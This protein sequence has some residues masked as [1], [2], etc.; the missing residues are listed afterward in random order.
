MTDLH[1]S[2][3][4]RLPASGAGCR[5]TAQLS[6]TTALC[7]HGPRSPAFVAGGVVELRSVLLMSLSAEDAETLFQAVSP[8]DRS[9]SVQ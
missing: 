9:Y 6:C 3:S 1:S 2:H 4:H 7:W 5:G 8:N